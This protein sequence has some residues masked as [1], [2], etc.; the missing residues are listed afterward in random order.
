MSSDSL[1]NTAI[2]KA[3]RRTTVCPLAFAQSDGLKDTTV[4]GGEHWLEDIRQVYLGLVILKKI[5]SI[6]IDL[7][8]LRIEKNRGGL[9]CCNKAMCYQG[10]ANRSSHL[11]L[12]VFVGIFRSLLDGAYGPLHHDDSSALRRARSPAV[13]PQVAQHYKVLC[14]LVLLANVLERCR[15]PNSA[16]KKWMERTPRREGHGE[17]PERNQ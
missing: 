1:T 10:L 3:G 8:I 11:S 13:K 15:L 14:L 5:L 4:C 6:Y 17:G 2:R 7:F 9:S 16:G 12:L